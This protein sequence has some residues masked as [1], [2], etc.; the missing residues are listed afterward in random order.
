MVPR[1]DDLLLAARAG[2]QLIDELVRKLA[3]RSFCIAPRIPGGDAG[4]PGGSPAPSRSE[5]RAR[6]T[7]PTSE[8]EDM[9][10]LSGHAHT[11]PWTL[12][13]V[14]EDAAPER[15]ILGVTNVGGLCA[16]ETGCT[17]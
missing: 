6:T 13:R 8:I 4:S 11:L 7:E 15:G 10:V 3:R 17:V 14:L 2:Q 5:T 12:H 16:G 1:P 9:T